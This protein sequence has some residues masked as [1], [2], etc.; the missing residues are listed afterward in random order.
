MFVIIIIVVVAVVVVITVIVVAALTLDVLSM[1]SGVECL[2][3][4]NHG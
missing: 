2:T 3:V 1:L 4:Q